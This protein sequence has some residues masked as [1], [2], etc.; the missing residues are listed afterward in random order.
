MSTVLQGIGID[1]LDGIQRPLDILS[2][3]ETTTSLQGATSIVG[4]LDNLYGAGTYARTTVVGSTTDG[5]TEAVIYNTHT[6]Q[7]L[8][9]TTIGTASG[10]GEARAPVRAEFQPIGYGSSSAFYLYSDHYKSGTSASDIAQRT[11]EAQAV[12]SDA[13]TLGAGRMSSSRGTSIRKTASR[14]DTRR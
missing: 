5:T 1:K 2:L 4:L 8:S 12:R 10:S 6:V 13:T 3:Q 14:P 7:L 11:A 9:Q